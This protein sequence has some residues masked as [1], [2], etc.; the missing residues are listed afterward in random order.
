ME[1]SPYKSTAGKARVVVIGDRTGIAPVREAVNVDNPVSHKTGTDKNSRVIAEAYRLG[2]I[3]RGILLLGIRKTGIWND[4]KSEEK[5]C[6]TTCQKFC[7]I[8]SYRHETQEEINNLFHMSPPKELSIFGM[9]PGM[10]PPACAISAPPPPFPPT[11]SAS[12]LTSFPA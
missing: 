1:F 2:F 9:L 8:V 7:S 5:E 6:Q 12:S 11:I 4:Q 10:F 3:L